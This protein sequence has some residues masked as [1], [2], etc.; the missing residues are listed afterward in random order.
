MLRMAVLAWLCSFGV[1]FAG[2]EKKP[3]APSKPAAK[4]QSPSKGS[5]SV[6]VP[7]RIVTVTEITREYAP[8]QKHRK[9]FFRQVG[10]A[11]VLT[12]TEAA[13]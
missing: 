8:V 7:S 6:A 2:D 12:H 11:K 10:N 4:T 5:E 1:I 3:Q 9:L 13:K